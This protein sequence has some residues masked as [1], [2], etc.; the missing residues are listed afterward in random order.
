[1][2][3]IAAA[4]EATALAQF[5]KGSQ[6]IY[7]LVN[8]GHVLGVA[9][10]VGAVVPLDLTLSGVLRRVDPA[11]AKALLRPFTI[12]GFLLAAGFGALLFI[13]QASDYVRNPTFL[14][15]I[16]LIGIAVANAWL[17][18]RIAGTNVV[19]ARVLALLSLALWPLVLLLGRLVGYSVG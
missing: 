1:M 16:G 14:A 15:K 4:L 3:E 18:S 8:A 10:L 12:A 6:W 7:P 19:V 11:A 17:H 5:L 2:N 13:T 9:L